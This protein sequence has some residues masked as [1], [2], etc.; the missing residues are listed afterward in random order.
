MQNIR[1]SNIQTKKLMAFICMFL[2]VLTP[3]A[4][5]VDVPRPD[6]PEETYNPNEPTQVSSTKN[7]GIEGENLGEAITVMVGDYQPK[8]IPTSVIEKGQVPIYVFLTGYSPGSAIFGQSSPTVEPFLGIPKIKDVQVLPEASSTKYISGSPQYIRPGKYESISNLGYLMV[9]LNRIPK[10]NDVPDNISLNMKMKITFDTNRGFGD[11]SMQDLVLQE[12]LDEASWKQI[13][14]GDFWNRKAFIRASDVSSSRAKLTVYDGKLSQISSF[15]L[16]AGE[17]SPIL[18]LPG[19]SPFFR[20][21]FQVQFNSISEP[22][23]KAIIRTTVQGQT[24]ELTLIKGMKLYPGS[25]WY[26][27]Q[28]NS[29]ELGLNNQ[30]TESIYIKSNLGDRRLIKRMYTRVPLEAT[31]DMFTT[32]SWKK[33]TDSIISPTGILKPLADLKNII[34]NGVDKIT[35]NSKKAFITLLKIIKPDDPTI[36][37]RLFLGTK[38]S[39]QIKSDSDLENI[40]KPFCKDQ[41]ISDEDLNKL[42]LSLQQNINTN[43]EKLY[44]TSIAVS[45]EALG[46]AQ[47]TQYISEIY[48]NIAEAYNGLKFLKSGKDVDS[49]RSIARNYY[50]K[51]LPYKTNKA[52]EAQKKIDSLDL[53]ILESGVKEE[54]VFLED[55]GAYVNLKETIPVTLEEQTSATIQKDP[56]TTEYYVGS[57][58]LQGTETIGTKTG[59]SFSWIISDITS[60]SVLLKKVRSGVDTG[61]SYTLQFG[62]LTQV[63][64][65]YVNDVEQQQKIPLKF[66][67]VNLKKEISVTVFPGAGVA[68][69]ESKFKIRIPVE[70]R[71]F[72]F[73]PEQIDHQINETQKLINQLDEYI[74]KLN[75][76]TKTWKAGCLITFAALTIKNSFLGGFARNQARKDVMPSY[77]QKCTDEVAQGG[78]TTIDKCLSKYSDQ[79]EKDLD[80]TQDVIKN[81]NDNYIKNKA[82]IKDIPQGISNFQTSTGYNLVTIEQLRDREKLKELNDKLLADSPLKDKIKEDLKNANNLID[83]K[84]KAYNNAIKIAGPDIPK[85]KEGKTI[86]T[87]KINNL[88]SVYQDATKYAPSNEDMKKL[89]S[90]IP[91][92]YGIANAGVI[93]GAF[94]TKDK[95]NYEGYITDYGEDGKLKDNGITQGNLRLAKLDD[96]KNENANNLR[97]I[98]S[99]N[100][101]NAADYIVANTAL[102]QKI[103]T[104]DGKPIYVD[105]NNPN[106]FYVASTTYYLGDKGT[107][108]NYAKD[109]TAEY[110]DKGRPYCIPTSNGNFVKVLEWYSTGDPRIIQE[111]N[112]GSDGLLCTS[113]DVLLN[114]ESQLALPENR[115]TLNDLTNSVNQAGSCKAGSNLQK[116]GIGTFACSQAKFQQNKALSSP[117]CA[118]VMDPSDCDLLYTA[119]DPV[120][121]PASRM[122]FAGRWQVSNVVETGIIGSI[123]LG[124]PNFPKPVVPICITGILAGM[125]NIK[126]ILEGY[127][128]CLQTSKVDGTSVGIC[129]QIRSIGLCE[130]LWKELIAIFNIKGGV[131]SFVADNIFNQVQGGG[132]YLTFQ[133]S[134]QNVANSVNFFTSDYA[135]SAF[136]AYMGRSTEEIGSEICK[137]AIYGKLPDIGDFFNQLTEPE[138]PPQFTA[139]FD[140]TPWVTTAGKTY[141]GLKEESRYSVYYHIY[142]GKAPT[143]KSGVQNN[144]VEFSVYLKDD[145]GRYLYTIDSDSSVTRAS[146]PQGG[147]IDKTVEA[148]GPA[149]LS[150]ICINLNGQES[151]GFGKVSSSFS[152]KYVA[153]KL[154]ESETS[155]NIISERDCVP[156]SPTSGASLGNLA[157]PRNYGLVST[158]VIR[159][160]ST[161]LPSD[162]WR[163]IGSCGKDAE[164]RSLGNCW[165]DLRSIKVN[166]KKVMNNILNNTKYNDLKLSGQLEEYQ[167]LM[168]NLYT[169]DK[170]NKI[171]SYLDID[172]E[173]FEKDVNQNGINSNNLK[174]ISD[175]LIGK[176]VYQDSDT[177]QQVSS[178]YRDVVANSVDPKIQARAQTKIGLIYLKLANWVKNMNAIK[179]EAKPAAAPAAEVSTLKEEE[180]PVE[181]KP[182][183]Q[184]QTIQLNIYSIGDTIQT[185]TLVS[186]SFN[187][188]IVDKNYK[189][190]MDPSADSLKVYLKIIEVAG[191]NEVIICPFSIFGLSPLYFGTSFDEE[192]ICKKLNLKIIPELKLW[193]KLNLILRQI[194]Q[195]SSLNEPTDSIETT[196]QQPSSSQT[197]DLTSQSSTEIIAPNEK[198]SINILIP[199][200]THEITINGV[201]PSTGDVDITIKSTPQNLNLKLGKEKEITLEGGKKVWVTIEKVDDKI[202]NLK[203]K[204]RKEETSSV[205]TSP[206]SDQTANPPQSSTPST[207][208]SQPQVTTTIP[209][210]EILKLGKEI[211]VYPSK[212]IKLKFLR[213]DSIKKEYAFNLYN[214]YD[215]QDIISDLNTPYTFSTI[216]YEFTITKKDTNTVTVSKIMIDPK[217]C[218]KAKDATCLKTGDECVFYNKNQ[219]VSSYLV[220]NDNTFLSYNSN[221]IINLIK[222]IAGDENVDKA[223][224]LALVEQES[225]YHQFDSLGRVLSSYK[226]AYGLLQ[227]TKTTAIRDT[228]ERGEFI[229]G[230]CNTLLSNDVKNLGQTQLN[231][232]CGINI[233]KE[234]YNRYKGGGIKA[235]KVGKDE[236]CP[237]STQC[238]IIT[239]PPTNY[240]GYPKKP[241]TE[242]V[243]NRYKSYI[244]WDAA[245]RA[246]NGRGCGP[247]ADIYFVENVNLKKK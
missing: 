84:T 75:D 211:D 81:V 92:D 235:I 120:M 35:I 204:I 62:K 141:L 192:F 164:G 220:S 59:L 49:L 116:P 223:L 128:Q 232:K 30:V 29:E 133:D 188:K 117:N 202:K 103:S 45:K 68:Y 17:K 236:G 237:T 96:L 199:G 63:P 205:S 172:F 41:I 182:L 144:D 93:P 230:I 107:I 153:D 218:E 126:S 214:K 51:V 224:I 11:I 233:L 53:E 150:Q 88:M 89:K 42:Q 175:V 231:I 33:V 28:I 112:V 145:Q 121:C 95:E 52:T 219:C 86:Y 171:L 123:V 201:N 87:S 242:Q 154:V 105:S 228:N 227:V 77:K 56:S 134:I 183:P 1:I 6:N 234:Y 99:K 2:I 140:E 135:K 225:N 160:C 246:Y 137:S 66:S 74:R 80:T 148:F 184:K 73:T 207:P 104:N 190:D 91:S 165:L 130:I 34:Y 32:A 185:K 239:S 118:D 245:L 100:K 113:D 166:D 155:K 156:D 151:C 44:C 215:K 217:R 178:G 39:I 136:A 15:S 61:I 65:N 167:K 180:S 163:R 195:D 229:K 147:Y 213:Y 222:E 170:S 129:D 243:V 200:E 210:G 71:P 40:E 21:Q 25:N 122:N 12:S 13:P 114:H 55:E 221:L 157:M 38:S 31:K 22:Q 46:K 108:R 70:K 97:A 179:V 37:E 5:A 101:D 72:Q 191:S 139:F 90:S 203:I 187:L 173:K 174:T 94:Q 20:D 209:K 181:S 197:L 142:A 115:G 208:S 132:E 60:E 226:D 18:Y 8:M 85:D 50:K 79:I 58:V 193:N 176:I 111:W 69:A 78:F 240:P 14:S 146:V 159:V 47:N 24:Y 177:Q 138:N 54:P 98:K 27:D 216:F 67:K 19:L 124:L 143:F 169:V 206:T 186:S 109:A 212:S 4:V 189:I 106:K 125:R 82:Y 119:C 57:E 158:G 23:D 131:V 83:T 127:M 247:S 152:L 48:F 10:E 110:D 16:S 161:S 196:T 162:D 102:N 238:C 43:S 7:T 9:V 64:I 198:K 194:N 244:G 241:T 76:V 168:S 36:T 3:L 26:V 149:H